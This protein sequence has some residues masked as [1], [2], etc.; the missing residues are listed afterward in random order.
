MIVPS[1]Y[2]AFQWHNGLHTH[3]PRLFELM[4][5]SH[6]I[7]PDDSLTRKRTR[8][9]IICPYRQGESS[10][11]EDIEEK[12][13][14]FPPNISACAMSILITPPQTPPYTSNDSKEEMRIPH[15]SLEDEQKERDE[16]WICDS[17]VVTPS[18]R[19]ITP[20][21]TAPLITTITAEL[22]PPPESPVVPPTIT[23]LHINTTEEKHQNRRSV[24]FIGGLPGSNKRDHAKR[25]KQDLITSEHIDKHR[26]SMLSAISQFYDHTKKAIVFDRSRIFAETRRLH[27]RFRDAIKSNRHDVIIVIDCF[28]HPSDLKEMT[29][30]AINMNFNVRYMQSSD[31][32]AKDVDICVERTRTKL[33]E[34]ALQH[35]SR[36][37]V[38]L[39][40]LTIN[41]VLNSVPPSHTMTLRDKSCRALANG[42]CACR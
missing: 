17:S 24:I 42:G 38:S 39:D 31:R 13:Q 23:P 3:Y 20:L 29:K 14:L 36:I 9:K 16:K 1:P 19:T 35:L 6:I 8:Q 40:T 7:A 12:W 30:L 41:T 4:H 11:T 21:T 28:P 27:G 26:I 33:C 5:D 18:E 2:A 34:Y 15:L 25:L 10:N 32:Y 37:L 22:L